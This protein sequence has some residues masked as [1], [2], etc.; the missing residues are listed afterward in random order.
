MYRELD[1]F[2]HRRKIGVHVTHFLAVRKYG[3]QMG[4][5]PDCKLDAGEARIS[6]FES[7]QR[8]LLLCNFECRHDAKQFRL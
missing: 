1:P 7:F 6:V 5:D 4:R 3:N 8:S 2:L